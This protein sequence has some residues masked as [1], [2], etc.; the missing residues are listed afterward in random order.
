MYVLGVYI[1]FLKLLSLYYYIRLLN[2]FE[3][4]NITL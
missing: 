1:V 3:S 2:I 4:I